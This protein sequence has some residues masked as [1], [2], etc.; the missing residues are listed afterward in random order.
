MTAC[1]DGKERRSEREDQAGSS[2]EYVNRGSGR[3]RD[4]GR[5]RGK[6]A[7]SWTDSKAAKEGGNRGREGGRDRGRGEGARS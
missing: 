7:N 5:G 1:N 2:L 4:R 6:D 3:D